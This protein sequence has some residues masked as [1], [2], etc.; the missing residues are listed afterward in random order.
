MNT[1]DDA[2]LLRDLL[3]IRIVEEEIAKRYPEQEMRCPTHLCIGQEATAVGVCRALQETDVV[4]SGHRSHGHYLA[5][6]GDLTRMIAEIYGRV[7]GCSRGKGGSMHLIDPSV[8]FLGAVPIVSSSIPMAVGA[9]FGFALRGES[10]VAAVFFGDA[11]VEEGVFHESLAFAM[12]ERLA[13]IFVC[14]NNL[15]S[16]QTP[17]S[18][19]QPSSRSLC[20]LARGHGMTA[21]HA[22]G[23]DVFA[24][25]SVARAAVERARQGGG[26]T[27][28]EL[29]T[30]RWLEHVG[31]DE[32]GALGYRSAEEINAWKERCPVAHAQKALLEREVVDAAGIGAL[33]RDIE[34]QVQQ[35][36]AAAK[37]APV[38]DAA[39]L[40]THVFTGGRTPIDRERL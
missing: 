10:R 13:V 12:L 36:F 22:D 27:F 11:A 37:S 35:A 33:R 4:F 14:E 30:Y 32:D 2:R 29:P 6:G 34:D 26:P 38:P 18:A 28:L 5:K 39:E 25:R 16:V 31:P 3:L 21:E 15:Y 9:A 8:G 23:N 20:D 1:P 7:S 19:R 40:L 24:V 17:L